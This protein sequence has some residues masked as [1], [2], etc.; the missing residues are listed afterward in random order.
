M[1]TFRDEGC[2]HRWYNVLILLN[3]SQQRRISNYKIKDLAERRGAGTARPC[4]WPQAFR[5]GCAGVCDNREKEWHFARRLR[6]SG[7]KNGGAS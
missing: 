3:L 6:E 2:S 7:M 1:R 4:F 5:A